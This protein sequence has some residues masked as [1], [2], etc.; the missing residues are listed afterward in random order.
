[1]NSEMKTLHDQREVDDNGEQ[2]YPEEAVKSFIEQVKDILDDDVDEREK[3]ISQQINK[4][5]GKNLT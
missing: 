1:M 4:L 3:Y 2:V 5:A